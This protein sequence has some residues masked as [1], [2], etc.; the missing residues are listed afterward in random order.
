MLASVYAEMNAIA[1]GVSIGI[2]DKG[3]GKVIEAVPIGSQPYFDLMGRRMYG[4]SF[5][6]VDVRAHLRS[7]S[8][9]YKTANDSWRALLSGSPVS[10][11]T[12]FSYIQ[13]SFRQ[14][15]PAVMGALYLLARSY[16]P[17]D[18]NKKGFTL[19]ADFRPEVKG[20][21]E[22]GTVKCDTILSLRQTRD[23]DALEGSNADT[24]AVVKLEEVD[25]V[26]SKS[27]S[28]ERESKVEKDEYDVALE[29]DP[30]S[31]EDLDALDIP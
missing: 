9:L 30:L 6:Q 23:S 3:K 1:K 21:G 7:T 4:H 12:A 15:M 2:Y 20:W 16:S 24:E 26:D 29:N 22:R 27:D 18:L 28:P 13:R 17:A 10:P 25:E 14:T 31:F 11:A 5:P 19:Y 8:P